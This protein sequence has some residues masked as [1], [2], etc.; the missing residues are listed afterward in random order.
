[1]HTHSE[2]WQHF[3]CT[4]LSLAVGQ[5]KNLPWVQNG[6][7]GFEKNI[8]YIKAICVPSEDYFVSVGLQ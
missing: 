7:V 5:I 6:P 4:F 8:P 1:M 3:Q 2:H